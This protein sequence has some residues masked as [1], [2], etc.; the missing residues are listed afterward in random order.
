M[1]GFVEDL[2]ELKQARERH[3]CGSFRMDN[4]QLVCIFV[5]DLICYNGHLLATSLVASLVFSSIASPFWGYILRQ[6]FPF[7]SSSDY[8][9]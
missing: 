8:K 9:F 1:Q 4:G 7:D 5:E 2:P 6:Y 3:G